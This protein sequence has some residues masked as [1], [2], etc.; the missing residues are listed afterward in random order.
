[1]HPP[2]NP[3][4]TTSSLPC[5]QRP[6]PIHAISSLELFRGASEL[7]IRHDGQ[8]YRLRITRQNKLILTK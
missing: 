2:V 1:V 7:V 5:V 3:S 6:A 8:D 4:P